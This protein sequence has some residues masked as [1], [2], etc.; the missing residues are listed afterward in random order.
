M[1][2]SVQEL[3]KIYGTQKAVDNISFEIATGEIVG[4]LGPNGAGKSTT[5]KMITCFLVP[6]SGTVIVNGKSIE[7]ESMEVRRLIGYL[8]EHNPLYTEMYVKEYLHFIAGLTKYKGNVSKRVKE[9][10]E[11]TGLGVEQHKKIGMLSKGYRQRIGLAQALL[12]DPEVLILDEPTSGLDPNQIIDIR[13][14]IK[15]VG[16]SKTIILSTHIMQEVQAMCSRVIIINKGNIVAD[17]PTSLL[18]TQASDKISVKVVF[19]NPVKKED[20]KKI[21]GVEE[22]I[23][24]GKDAWIVTSSSQIDLRETLFLWAAA[25]KH[26]IYAM[27]IES[28]SLENVFHKLTKAKVAQINNP[29]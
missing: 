8:P 28:Q 5:M 24:E 18:T 1:T 20:L 23:S 4:F 14:L 19:K 15:E 9:L 6:T 7:D 10:V 2:V 12:N 3:T 27:Q 16:K 22:V 25:Q 21:A 17:S 26:I 11:M 13:N 29:V